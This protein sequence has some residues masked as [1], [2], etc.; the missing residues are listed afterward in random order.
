M[1]IRP[2]TRSEADYGSQRCLSTSNATLTRMDTVLYQC[3]RIGIGGPVLHVS[4][5]NGR[6]D[7]RVSHLS[8]SKPPDTFLR[9]KDDQETDLKPSS[10]APSVSGQTSHTDNG[11]RQAP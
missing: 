3:L 10:L 2:L 6:G 11:A 1:V 4:R 7:K 8:S 5:K 9:N